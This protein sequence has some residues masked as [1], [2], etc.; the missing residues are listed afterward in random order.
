MKKI[1]NM[2]ENVFEA[3][4]AIW[5]HD[6]I[7]N[8]G[9]KTNENESAE[10]AE[11][12]LKE[13]GVED[14]ISIEKVK[15]MIINT[16]YS[17]KNKVLSNDEKLLIDLDMSILGSLRKDYNKYC[18]NIRKEHESISEEDFYRGRLIFIENML[19]KNS[20]FKTLFFKNKYEKMAKKNLKHELKEIRIK[21]KT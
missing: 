16:D 4:A 9:S 5:F 18:E 7:Y 8:I 20:I 12:Y 11:R 14:N 10:Y 15:S 19:S 1:K 3:E 13:I 17:L 2:F 6:I 21:W